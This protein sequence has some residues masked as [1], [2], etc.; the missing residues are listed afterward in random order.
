MA[1]LDGRAAANSIRRSATPRCWCRDPK[2]NRAHEKLPLTFFLFSGCKAED[3]FGS[4]PP[5]PPEDH[6]ATEPFWSWLT[7]G[8]DL[9]FRFSRRR[10]PSRVLR[11][12]TGAPCWAAVR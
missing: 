4:R 9:A 7:F 10:R 2:C 12:V 5:A 3:P 6:V 1:R 8:A 11:Q